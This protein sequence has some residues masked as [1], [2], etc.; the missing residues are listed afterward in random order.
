MI[1]QKLVVQAITN[2][3]SS[4]QGRQK[5]QKN[6]RDKTELKKKIQQVYYKFISHEYEWHFIA[7]YMYN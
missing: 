3:F 4:D 2:L 7:F 5:P 1:K 6:W